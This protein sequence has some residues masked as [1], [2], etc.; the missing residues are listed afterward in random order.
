MCGGCKRAADKT[1]ANR[2]LGGNLIFPHACDYV[3]TCPC[4][5]SRTRPV[6]PDKPGER[7]RVTR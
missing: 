7:K 3:H 5:H 6:P 1:L 2:N 4:Q